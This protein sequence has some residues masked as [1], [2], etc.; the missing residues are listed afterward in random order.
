MASTATLGTRPQYR[1]VQSYYYF[2]I[3]T[4]SST[5]GSYAQP[6]SHVELLDFFFQVF[7]PVKLP[8][9]TDPEVFKFLASSL[10]S[11]KESGAKGG[12]LSFLVNA[13]S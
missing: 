12:S 4:P 10:F 7:I 13:P 6:E 9:E 2:R 3:Q 1:F 11:T 5:K 8:V